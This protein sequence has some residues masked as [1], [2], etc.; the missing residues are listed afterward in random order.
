MTQSK[1]V[2]YSGMFAEIAQREAQAFIL[3]R[4]LLTWED[5]DI[6]V[7][8][9]SSHRELRMESTGRRTEPGDE[10]PMHLAGL[11]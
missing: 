11:I 1:R 6:N 4:W 10:K 9:D 2:T 8:A 5:R 7:A 3:S